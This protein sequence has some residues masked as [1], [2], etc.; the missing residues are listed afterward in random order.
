MKKNTEQI[1]NNEDKNTI[2]E[3]NK[4]EA[5]LH[6]KPNSQLK[7]M[8]FSD[9]RIV[10]HAQTFYTE[11]KA[12]EYIQYCFDEFINAFISTSQTGDSIEE[13]L[14]PLRLGLHTKYR[15]QFF[16]ALLLNFLN[17]AT[18][19]NCLVMYSTNIFTSIGFAS[20]A[21]LLTIIT[22]MYVIL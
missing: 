4:D 3:N 6:S 2:Q 5:L 8:Y 13:K 11:S 9:E 22:G 15:K 20:S 7:K 18:G 16:I 21:N 17:Q 19:I 12:Q 10:K 1:N 14:G